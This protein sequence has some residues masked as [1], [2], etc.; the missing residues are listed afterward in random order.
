LMTYETVD[1]TTRAS[2]AT[3]FLVTRALACATPLGLP[4]CGAF[5]FWDTLREH[6]GNSDG[7]SSASVLCSR[8]L[9]PP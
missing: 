7:L 5:I 3:S 4:V 9:L 8:L 1:G 2:L 6:T